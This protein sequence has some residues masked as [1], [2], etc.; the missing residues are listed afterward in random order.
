[1]VPFFYYGIFITDLAAW[2][3]TLYITARDQ[4]LGGKGKFWESLRYT[5]LIDS[6]FQS[7][8]IYKKVRVEGETKVLNIGTLPFLKTHK[9]PAKY[10][11]YKEDRTTYRRSW[12]SKII[13]WI[14]GGWEQFVNLVKFWWEQLFS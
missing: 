12:L 6:G 3:S 1:A 4:S 10:E 7:K 8:S 13:D 5:L 2:K 11:R 14:K 9:F